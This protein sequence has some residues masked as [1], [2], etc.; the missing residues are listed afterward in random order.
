MKG[1]DSL[2]INKKAFV[3]QLVD[4]HHYTKKAANELVDDFWDVLRDNM[5]VG[6]TVT[7]YGYGKFQLV[8]RAPR[9]TR[10]FRTGEEILV[11]FHY[12]TKF[13][14]GQLFTVA[15]RTY[16]GDKRRGLI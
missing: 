10:D 11:P 16:E 14:P 8:E 9:K 12:F 2:N 7:F 3:Q 6:N 1:N 15:A 4:K 13:I 5:V